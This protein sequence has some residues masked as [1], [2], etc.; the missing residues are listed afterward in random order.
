MA[1][2]APRITEDPSKQCAWEAGKNDWATSQQIQHENISRLFYVCGPPKHS[3]RSPIESP[4]PLTSAI[5]NCDSV[6]QKNALAETCTVYNDEQY[7][8]TQ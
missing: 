8:L 2:S 6:N 4:T 7:I 1:A 3:P 5:K